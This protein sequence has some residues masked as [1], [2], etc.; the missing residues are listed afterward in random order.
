[1]NTNQ[2]I[3]RQIRLARFPDGIPV[4]G[5]FELA[6]CPLPEPEAG[7][8]LCRTRYL[9]LDPYMRS[10]IAGRHISGSLAPGDMMRGESVCEVVGSGNPDFAEAE[11]E[12][13]AQLH[14][15]MII[16]RDVIPLPI[17]PPSMR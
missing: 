12:L 5:D 14:R 3:N 17:L 11:H 4:E 13:M 2:L 1:M 16:Y 9:S 7:Q 8:L 15:W 10:Q 6:E